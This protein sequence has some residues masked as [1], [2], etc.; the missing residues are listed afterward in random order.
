M[1]LKSVLTILGLASIAVAV[2]NSLVT[3]EDRDARGVGNGGAPGGGQQPPQYAP[4]WVPQAPYGPKD[5][6]GSPEFNKT[7]DYLA[8]AI[9]TKDYTKTPEDF[10]TWASE[11]IVKKLYPALNGTHC[12]SSLLLIV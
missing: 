9:A 5:F 11:T 7:A 3:L 6:P 12:L 2:P 8:A 10:M 1:Y 4:P